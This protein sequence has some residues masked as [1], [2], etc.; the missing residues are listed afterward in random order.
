MNYCWRSRKSAR[1]DAQCLLNM[2]VCKLIS[3][4]KNDFAISIDFGEVFL[5]LVTDVYWRVSIK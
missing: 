2:L 3:P 4:R 1:L 5:T